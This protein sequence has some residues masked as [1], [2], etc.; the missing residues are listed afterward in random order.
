MV[1]HINPPQKMAKNQT[2]IVLVYILLIL[3]KI[4]MRGTHVLAEDGETD[5]QLKRSA[6]ADR[7]NQTEEEK[8][9]ENVTKQRQTRKKPVCTKDPLQKKK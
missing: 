7:A 3:P 2:D 9:T 6:D 1:V 4:K 5:E 8:E